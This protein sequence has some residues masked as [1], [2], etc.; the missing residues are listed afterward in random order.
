MER[1][2]CLKYLILAWS[3]LGSIAVLTA[4]PGPRQQVYQAFISDRMDAWDQVIRDLSKRRA[5]LSDAQ[6]MDLINYYYG[7]VGWAIGQGDDAKARDYIDE[8]ELLIERQLQEHP[9]VPDLYA[10]KGAF[11]GFRIGLNKIKAVVLGPESMKNINHAV[12]IG[13]DRPQGWIERGN[14]LFYMPRMFGGSKEKALE[15]YLEAIR[16]MERVPDELR[17][18]WMYLNVLMILGQAYEQTGQWEKAKITYE[19][20]LRIEPRFTYMR[21]EV[22]P[23]FLKRW[24]AKA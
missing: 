4:Q 17:Q 7:Y 16:L 24:E 15:A 22:Y 19:K 14:A 11:I 2:K 3:L 21:D 18:N 1:K 23:A 8:A 5:D 12:E 6:V 13:P 20:L 10:Y 9:Q